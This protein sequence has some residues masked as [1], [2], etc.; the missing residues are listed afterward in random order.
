MGIIDWQAACFNLLPAVAMIPSFLDYSGGKYVGKY[1][2][3]LIPP[4]CSSQKPRLP[5]KFEGL[6]IKCSSKR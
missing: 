2:P 6:K 1:V 3:R 5:S 4:D